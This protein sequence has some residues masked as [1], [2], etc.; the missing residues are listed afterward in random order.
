MNNFDGGVKVML[1]CW[2]KVFVDKVF[3]P[4]LKFYYAMFNLNLLFLWTLLST[5]TLLSKVDPNFKKKSNILI[6]LYLKFGFRKLEMH[7]NFSGL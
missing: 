5:L 3:G 2:D 1:R 4:T 6:L 7:P